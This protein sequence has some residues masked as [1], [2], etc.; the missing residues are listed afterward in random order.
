[1]AGQNDGAQSGAES[2]NPRG[3]EQTETMK[4]FPLYYLIPL[5]CMAIG[6]VLGWKT[7]PAVNTEKPSEGPRPEQPPAAAIEP[8]TP[9]SALLAAEKPGAVDESI[10]KA[11]SY[12]SALHR[13]AALKRYFDTL[14]DGEFATA[15]PKVRTIAET[16]PEVMEMLARAWVERAPEEAGR[17]MLTLPEGTLRSRVLGAFSRAWAR[18]NPAVAMAWVEKNLTGPELQSAQS[19]LKSVKASQSP[20]PKKSLEEIVAVSSDSERQTLLYRHFQDL[21]K[22]NPEDAMK[23]LL[24]VPGQSDRRSLQFSLTMNWAQNDPATFVR[25]LKNKESKEPSTGSEWTNWTSALSRASEQLLAKDPGLVRQL[26]GEFPEGALKRH[27]ANLYATKLVKDD[28][29]AALAF[30][31]EI[32]ARDS[33][34]SV[35]GIL[36]E[37]LAKDS[38]RGGELLLR[39]LQKSIGEN[40]TNSAEFAARTMKPWINKDA[41]AAAAFATKM[42]EA[43]MPHVFYA[44]AEVWCARDGRAA[45]D[46][47]SALPAGKAKENAIREFTYIWA[48]HD[49]KQSTAWINALPSDES[50]WAATEGFVFSTIDTDPDAA[51]GWARSI[52]D[53][54]K[55]LGI[56]K[57]AW[58]KWS[59]NNFQSAH[60]WLQN[61]GLSEK[62]R[63]AISSE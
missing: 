54:A 13:T 18:K 16:Q 31:E 19:Y 28:A 56:V 47:A 45:L 1:M 22:V 40:P 11:M 2:G 63:D 48:K 24:A 52:P 6:A 41:A 14:G 49:T 60:D 32:Q 30:V 7:E 62:E 34:F 29:D 46:W 50:R 39:E 59:N 4:K 5:G 20:Q 53:E 27:L 23:Q 44:V 26:V 57:R 38:E 51:L 3:T 58:S 61:G 25:W 10:E 42:P 36:P 43:A 15:F 33:S 55:R 8:A 21:M 37:L 17:A 35:S 9:S 12:P